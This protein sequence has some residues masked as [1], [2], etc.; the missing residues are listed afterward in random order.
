MRTALSF[1]RVHC[2]SHFREREVRALYSEEPVPLKQWGEV[3]DQTIDQMLGQFKI[4]LM[5]ER[6][7][8][9]LEKLHRQEHEAEHEDL[10]NQ[11]RLVLADQRVPLED[12]VRM[13]ASVGVVFSGLFLAGDAFESTDNQQLGKLLRDIL[14]GVLG[15]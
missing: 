3:L 14:H 15:G 6:N 5:H 7:Q 8:A 9:A 12:R 1:L 11:L 2:D 10:Q 13:A 4:F